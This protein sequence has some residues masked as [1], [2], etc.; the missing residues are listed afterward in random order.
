MYSWEGMK[1]IDFETAR[2]YFCYSNP[3]YK[4]SGGEL[5]YAKEM[6]FNNGIESSGDI[7]TCGCKDGNLNIE[8][9]TDDLYAVIKI[10]FCLK[11]GAKL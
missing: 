3:V 11:C 2:R 8:T 7:S 1:K 6:V 10:Y 5:A 9:G 4:T